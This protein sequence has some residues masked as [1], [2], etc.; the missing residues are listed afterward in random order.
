ME[1]GISEAKLKRDAPIRYC[2]GLSGIPPKHTHRLPAHCILCS[3]SNHRNTRTLRRYGSN[4]HRVALELP[5]WQTGWL[6]DVQGSRR[7]AG[8][9]GQNAVKRGQG[10]RRQQNAC[11]RSSWHKWDSA[12]R[13]E[14][15]SIERCDILKGR[16][17]CFG[18]T[19][20]DL[21]SIEN[22]LKSTC[23]RTFQF[24]I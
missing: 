24:I 23:N 8:K 19:K 5:W 22:F 14:T 12:L 2:H 1:H 20:C 18:K 9:S 10:W 6:V 16:F 4:W 7:W 11:E 17:W 13:V 3:S 21:D 15:L